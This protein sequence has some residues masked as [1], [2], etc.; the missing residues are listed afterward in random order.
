MRVMAD[1][2][3]LDALR[4]NAVEVL[5]DLCPIDEVHR[6]A[7]SDEPFARPLW[8]KVAE[9]GW[10]M[11]AVPEEQGGMGGGIAELAILQKA[12]GAHLAPLPTIG[13]A[14]L[15]E[16]LK[17]WADQDVAAELLGAIAAGEVIGGVADLDG[18]EALTLSGSTVSGSTAVVDGVQADWLLV[19]V[20]DGNGE[21]LALI[22]GSAS[23][24]SRAARPI[25]DRTRSLATLSCEGTPVEQV[26]TGPAAEALL[27]RLRLL[28]SL[29][30]ACDAI[31]GAEAALDVTV[32]Y[33]KTRVQFGKPIGSF[34]ALKHRA[35]DIKTKVEMA[36]QLVEAAVARA[37]DMD[38]ALWASMAKFT[39][40]EAYASVTAE[41]VQMHGGIGYTDEHSAHLYLK[42]ATMNGAL[43]GSARVQQDRAA[44]ALIA[45]AA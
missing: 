5:D 34:Q 33:L 39:A 24:I 11:L 43:F 9:L 28:A 32:E 36:R 42:R 18:A 26:V 37:D 19:R 6:A 12:Y 22:P 2:E 38:A 15:T 10:L 40:C 29:L 31:G 20:T 16:A 14:L 44:D 7:V 27:N 21:G 25:A 30:V 17:S 23:G 1:Q 3:F 45:R 35:A 8:E 4:T 13:T 41:M